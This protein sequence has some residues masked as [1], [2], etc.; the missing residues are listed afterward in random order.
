LNKNDVEDGGRCIM[1]DS[2]LTFASRNGIK[3]RKVLDITRDIRS[4]VQD[5]DHWHIGC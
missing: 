3:A 4:S 5:S 1:K 2:F